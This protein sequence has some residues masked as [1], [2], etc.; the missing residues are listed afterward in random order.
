MG[1]RSALGASTGAILRLVIGGGLARV[2]LGLVIGVAGAFALTRTM[3]SLLF[4]VGP[5]D[6][7]SM[8]AAALGL[9]LVAVLACYV[10]ARRAT[11]VD[12]MVA[13]RYE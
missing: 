3:K 2:G 9:F 13:L 11:R 8:G 4:G 1:L 12:P 5:A 6:P 7:W 10:P